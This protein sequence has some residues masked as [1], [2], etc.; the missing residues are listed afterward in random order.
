MNDK[1]SKIQAQL[2]AI[3]LSYIESLKSK[4]ETIELNWASLNNEWLA[5]T[6]D[7]LYLVIH[8]LAGSAETFGFPQITQQARVVVNQFK[9]LNPHHPPESGNLVAQIDRNIEILMQTLW[10][11]T[12]NS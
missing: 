6:Y 1:H 3:R 10:D 12:R 5:D 8:G 2:D 7:A 9:E 11:T 4:R